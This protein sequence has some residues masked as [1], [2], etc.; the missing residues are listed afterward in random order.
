[1][2]AASI[3][4]PAPAWR[5]LRYLAVTRVLVASAVALTLGTLG[6]RGTLSDPATE[7]LLF[8]AAVYVVAA[9]LLAA[10]AVLVPRRFLAQTLAQLT[11]DLACVSAL[12]VASGGL[13]GGYAILYLL[14]LAGA[15]LL[16]SRV[17]AFFFCA[18]AVLV[19]LFD[20]GLRLFAPPGGEPLIFQAGV[21]GAALFGVTYLLQWLSE[22]LAGQERL[23]AARGRDLQNQLALNRLVIAQMDQ[24]VIVVDRDG[25]VRANNVAARR[26]FGLL[27]EAQVTGRQLGEVPG[28]AALEAAFRQWLDGAARGAVPAP[29]QGT[30]TQAQAGAPGRLAAR[31][32]HP[33]AP[34][35]HEMLILVQDLR[36]VESRAQ[37]LK[38]AAMGRLTASIA[39]EIRNPLAAISQAGQF[40]AEDSSDP[41]QLRLASIVR[42]NTRRLNS[43]VEN[44]LRVARREPSSAD[45]FRLDAF[46]TDWLAA[47]IADRELAPDRIGL[48]LA[49]SLTVRFEPSQLRQVVD[50]LVEN[51]LRY[52]TDAPGAVRLVA[53]R[54]IDGG[55]ELWVLDDGPGL[56]GEA[57]AALFE[58]FYTSRAQG[59]GLGL[60]LAREFCESNGATL[61]HAEYRAVGQAQR[62]GF[63]L[64]FGLGRPLEADS[65]PTQ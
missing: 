51:A 48:D 52:C 62:E 20:A 49:P 24:G 17:L 28:A 27:P 25:R 14:P 58:P 53:R 21:F 6:P 15:S 18:V 12:L 60:F 34:D 3:L 64:R 46:L 32:I 11:L 22:R 63:V 2:A 50:N 40:L 26:M 57:R 44:V 4:D 56:S 54:S 7:R 1:V 35:A 13:P 39:H 31:F 5:T 47:F 59:T 43:L 36:E 9:A 19:V 8:I 61:A 23:A 37:Q 41:L 65:I 16:L 33:S 30:L 45:E 42:D 38:L 29:W 10:L 55:A